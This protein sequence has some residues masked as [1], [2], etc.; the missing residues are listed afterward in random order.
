M[1]SQAANRD[2]GVSDGQGPTPETLSAECI[3]TALRVALQGKDLECISV[4][5]IR[6][7]LALGFGFPA[8]GLDC[9]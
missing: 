3:R 7:Q 1:A 6:K 9:R 4:G 8:E 5:E 2:A